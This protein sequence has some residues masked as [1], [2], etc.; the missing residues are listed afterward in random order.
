MRWTY[1]AA[2]GMALLAVVPMRAI[3]WTHFETAVRG[4]PV[5]RDAN[6][7]RIVKVEGELNLEIR[8]RIVIDASG[9]GAG[10]GKDE[11]ITQGDFDVEPSFSWISTELTLTT[12]PS[13]S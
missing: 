7:H 11:N 1:I 10:F 8:A 9:P 3:E 13:I 6:G 4:Y 2:L 12:T 5:M